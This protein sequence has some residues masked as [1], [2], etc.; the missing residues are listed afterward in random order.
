MLLDN[1][2]GT[3]SV[4]PRPSLQLTMVLANGDEIVAEGDNWRTKQRPDGT[5]VAKLRATTTTYCINHEASDA[6]IRA[7]TETLALHGV[8]VEYAWRS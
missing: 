8:A 2:D 3:V 7:L 5:I 4:R 6:Q 1:A